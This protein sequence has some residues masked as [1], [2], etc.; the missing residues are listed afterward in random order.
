MKLESDTIGLTY[1]PTCVIYKG[2]KFDAPVFLTTLQS[3][4]LIA[5]WLGTGEYKKWLK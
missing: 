1:R 5:G 3:W 2:K 4:D